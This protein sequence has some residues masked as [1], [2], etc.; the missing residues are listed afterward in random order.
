ME[1]KRWAH[2]TENCLYRILVTGSDALM[3]PFRIF[4]DRL[5]SVTIP[6]I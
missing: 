5:E 3:L 2:T 4:V 1:S 6:R